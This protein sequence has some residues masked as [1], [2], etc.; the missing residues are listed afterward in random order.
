[1]LIVVS[2]IEGVGK[3][4][5]FLQRDVNSNFFGNLSVLPSEI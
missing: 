1:M 2:V 4:S 3:M 5:T